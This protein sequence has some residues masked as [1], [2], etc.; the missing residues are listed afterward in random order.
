MAFI[1]LTD[2]QKDLLLNDVI[3][4]SEVKWGILNKAT[5]WLGQDGTAVPGGQNSA[6]LAR[7]AKSRH[8]AAIISL[9]P[10]IAENNLAV[11]YFLFQAKNIQC[12]DDQQAF[13][14]TLTI[15]K[16]LSLSSFDALSDQ[17]FDSQ[18]QNTQF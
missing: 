14:T 18:I 12:V 8:Y 2:L 9:N 4:Q 10:S 7:W 6:S 5:Y 17:W 15:N 3:F 1:I 13:T 16:L 11:K